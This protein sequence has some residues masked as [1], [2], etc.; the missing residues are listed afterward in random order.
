LERRATVIT[1]HSHRSHRQVRTQRN[2]AIQPRNQRQ[3]SEN[4]AKNKLVGVTITACKLIYGLTCNA[5]YAFSSR[6]KEYSS[7]WRYCNV[8]CHY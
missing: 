4:G 7:N 3:F 5:M 8:N 1:G 6:Q 2:P